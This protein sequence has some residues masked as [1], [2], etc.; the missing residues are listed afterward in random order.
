MH[1]AE[2]KYR[3]LF[4]TVKLRESLG[5]TAVR[6]G[7]ATMAAEIGLSILRIGSTA[8]LARILV[9]ADFGLLAMVTAFTIFA[10][11]FKDFGLSDATVQAKDIN[12]AQVTALFWLNLLICVGIALLLAS[13]SKLIA[14]F[15]DEPR[16]TAVSLVIASTFL[17]SGLVIQ[18]E[19]LMR[20]QL[21]FA[22]LAYIQLCSTT[23][24]IFVAILLAYYGFGYWALVAR[25]FS[26]AMFVVVG[27]WAAC[28]WRPGRPRR[29][30]GLAHFISFGRNVTGFNL[31][32]FFS[33]SLDKILIGK[34]FGAS[35]VGLYVNAYQL[36][37]LP[38]NQIQY[39]LNTVAMPALS[40]IQAEPSSFRSYYEKMIQLLTFFTMPVV[41]FCALFADV[42]I[43]LILGPK[44]ND[45]VPIFRI[46]AVG[47]FMEPL[48]HA[49]GPALV[50]LGKTKAYFK[51]GVINSTLLVF[52]LLFG[53]I[54]GVF[55][56][57]VGYSIAV[58]LSLI[59]C[60]VYGF[61]QTPIGIRSLLNGLLLCCLPSFFMALVLFS[62]RYSIGWTLTPQLFFLCLIT[63]ASSYLGLWLLIPGGKSMLMNYWRYSRDVLDSVKSRR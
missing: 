56:V 28:P 62:I 32:N 52:C 25:E 37:A 20:R 2:E 12:H 34:L 57:A 48:V 47:A 46:L 26:R 15:Y 14:I 6:G 39:P 61:R 43:G 36:I 50:A 59:T 19:A 51:L 8:V 49:T 23:L 60:L 42:I 29:E 16:L 1:L 55:G 45:A 3:D 58:Y 7:A 27:M 11:R 10:E 40:A 63:A 30:A 18:H 44:W 13:A 21:R 53:S 17:F 31:L 24:S 5:K 22:T 41:I 4:S 54:W 9:P 35:W 33:R 38:V